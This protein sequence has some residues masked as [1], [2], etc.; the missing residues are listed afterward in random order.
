[1]SKVSIIGAV[2]FLFMATIGQQLKEARLAKNKTFQDLT[3]TTKIRPFLLRCLEEERYDKF[4]DAFCLQSFQRQY[5]RALGLD[6]SMAVKALPE[7]PVT[8]SLAPP[9]ERSVKPST[10]PREYLAS[11]AWRL[12]REL[13][14]NLGAFATVCVAVVLIATGVYWWQSLER[15]EDGSEIVALDQPTAPVARSGN[16]D[17]QVAEVAPPPAVLASATPDVAPLQEPA[18]I[19]VEIRATDRLW[20][21]CLVDESRES[22][23]TLNAGDRKLLRAD[24]VVE[25]SVGNAAVAALVVEGK[26]HDNIGTRGQ[27]R[28]MR[29]T[30]EG[31]SFV[32]P[33]SF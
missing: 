15:S 32:P 22:E 17:A 18:T 26:L 2:P 29:I 23:F 13:K 21:R 14:G 20:V 19:E 24:S 12:R 10:P 33:G 28:H 3:E 9:P 25:V 6:E 1:M 4:P 11:A 30:H 31:W 16:T 7:L 5:A 27:V 8:A